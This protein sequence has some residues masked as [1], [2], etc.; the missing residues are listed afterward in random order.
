M[1]ELG[2]GAGGEGASWGAAVASSARA[3]GALIP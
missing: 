1:L 3:N 2:R